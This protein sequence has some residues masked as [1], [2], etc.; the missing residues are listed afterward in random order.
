M[1]MLY[2]VK[3]FLENG[4]NYAWILGACISIVG[5]GLSKSFTISFFAFLLALGYFTLSERKKT[6]RIFMGIVL[7]GIVALIVIGAY[8][9]IALQSFAGN[10]YF[11][12]LADTTRTIVPYDIVTTIALNSSSFFL[13]ITPI[14]MA[15]V[16]IG[17]YSLLKGRKPEFYALWGIGSLIMLGCWGVLAWY[18]IFFVPAF[19]VLVA[20]F[21][22]DTNTKRAVLAAILLITL[23]L[24]VYIPMRYY[25]ITKDKM[26]IN[27]YIR[28]LGENKTLIIIQQGWGE[29]DAAYGLKYACIVTPEIS[30]VTYNRTTKKMTNIGQLENFSKRDNIRGIVYNYNN[31]NLY[32]QFVEQLDITFSYI[33][34]VARTHKNFEG[35]FDIIIVKSYYYA[36]VRE[37]LPEYEEINRTENSE[38]YVLGKK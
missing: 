30:M 1:L 18:F 32:P 3:Q 36:A 11:S 34:P 7:G 29:A 12:Y 13:Y 21:E 26:Q 20:R 10:A 15:A 22:W 4:K 2:C 23:A 24:D 37:A 25:E 38:Y 27:E 6:P 33:P 31:R 35:D 16:L 17:I 28:G 9:L 5:V 8:P 19:A 14:G